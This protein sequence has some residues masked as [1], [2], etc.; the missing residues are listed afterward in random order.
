MRH[1]RSVYASYYALVCL[2]FLILE[3]ISNKQG[4]KEGD[5]TGL[6][7]QAALKFLQAASML[8]SEGSE[9]GESRNPLNIYA[10]TAKLCE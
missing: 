4:G 9:H 3:H 10:D 2:R 5:G 7:F 6:Y 1:I 8:E